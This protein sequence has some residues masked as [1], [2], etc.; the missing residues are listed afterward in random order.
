MASRIQATSSLR[1]ICLTVFG[2]VA[3]A[4]WPATNHSGTIGVA[5]GWQGRPASRKPPS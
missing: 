5:A 1:F 2:D 4:A 3:S